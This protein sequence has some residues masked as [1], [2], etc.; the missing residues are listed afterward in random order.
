MFEAD[1]MDNLLHFPFLQLTTHRLSSFRLF[2]ITVVFENFTQLISVH[3]R[4]AHYVQENE[5]SFSG[6]RRAAT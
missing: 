3:E 5:L 2:P 1:F 4:G 6:R